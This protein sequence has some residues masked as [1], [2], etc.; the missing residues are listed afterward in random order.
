MKKIIN[1]FEKKEQLYLAN[2]QFLCDIIKKK[3]ME[4]SKIKN[5]ISILRLKLRI[6]SEKLKEYENSNHL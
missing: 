1:F 2:K 6:L 4:I 5:D 3:N